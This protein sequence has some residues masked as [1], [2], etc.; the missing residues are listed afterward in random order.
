MRYS[1]RLTSIAA[2]AILTVVSV[3]APSRA[4][5][6]TTTGSFQGVA[7]M[8]VQQFVDGGLV[9]DVT[10]TNVASTINFTLAYDASNPGNNY[11]QYSI[12]N[13]V[14][15]FDT[16]SVPRFLPPEP[17][18]TL[19]VDGIPGQSADSADGTIERLDPSLGLIAT[20]A[21]ADPSGEFIGPNGNGDPSDVQINASYSYHFDTTSE[22]SG[23][24]ITTSFTAMPA[25]EPSSIVLAASGAM[26]I[27]AV[28]LRR[29]RRA[30]HS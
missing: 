29:A 26:I 12:N 13:S 4:G 18:T 30:S 11:M 9:S 17:Y 16:S 21:L 5:T 10:Y 7:N 6:I 28:A 1:R 23:M 22:R 14:Y 19:V 24:A 20:F 15:S 2:L 27:L 3:N 25:P 8:E